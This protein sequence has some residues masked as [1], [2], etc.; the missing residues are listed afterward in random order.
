MQRIVKDNNNNNNNNYWNRIFFNIIIF[1]N[2][3]RYIY[4]YTS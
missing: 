4:I 2:L 1:I 3:Y